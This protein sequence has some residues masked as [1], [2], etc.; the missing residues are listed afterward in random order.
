M[1]EDFKLK[2]YFE[3]YKDMPMINCMDFKSKF[4][5]KHGN[6]KYLPELLVMINK[7]QVSNYGENISNPSNILTLEEKDRR[8]IYSNLRVKH[9][10]GNKRDRNERKL[11]YERARKNDW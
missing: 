4:I 1:S 9:K 8:R 7:Y 10:F 5:K 2:Y 11:E 6:F 3:V